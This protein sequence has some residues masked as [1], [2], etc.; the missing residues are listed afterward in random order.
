MVSQASKKISIKF[1]ENCTY[2]CKKKKYFWMNKYVISTI[3]VSVNKKIR[4]KQF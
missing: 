2:F 1:F 3:K 4:N